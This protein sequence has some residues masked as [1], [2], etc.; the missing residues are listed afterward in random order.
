MSD[1]SAHQLG[2]HAC[3]GYIYDETYIHKKYM[4]MGNCMISFFL[5]ASYHKIFIDLFLSK[6]EKGYVKNGL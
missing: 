4:L 6:I 3:N 2:Y 5:R 1:C